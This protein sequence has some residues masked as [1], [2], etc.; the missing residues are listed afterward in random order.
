MKKFLVLFILTSTFACTNLEE[1]IYDRI[2]SDRFPENADQAALKVLPAYRELS[3]LIDDVGWWFWAQE[4]TSDEVVFPVRLTD[5]EDGGKWYL[6]HQ[7]QWT[8]NIDA[9]NTMWSNLYD[10]VTEANRAIDEL[11]GSKDLITVAKLKTLRAFY[12]YLL[13]D[14]Y[15]NVPLVTSFTKADKQPKKTDKKVIYDFIVKDIRKIGRAHV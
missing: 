9:V 14:N 12:Y 6:L 13:I 4:V 1:N 11:E 5:W 3:D 2:P 15:G 7:H 10:G 8:N